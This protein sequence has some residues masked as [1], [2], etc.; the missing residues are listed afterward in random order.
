EMTALQL[1][2]ATVVVPI[3]FAT[4]TFVPILLSP[5][6]LKEHWS[7]TDAVGGPLLGG[8]VLILF[9]SILIA[10]R[11]AVGLLFAGETP[12]REGAMAVGEPATESDLQQLR[13]SRRIAVAPAYN[14][15]P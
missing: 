3:S 1:R 4:Q 6:F 13:P 2:P 7:G 8:L 14:E 15:E 9:A 10:R 12:V 11:P 5:L